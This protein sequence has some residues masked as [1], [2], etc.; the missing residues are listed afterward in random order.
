MK[1]IIWS[2]VIAFLLSLIFTTT[3]FVL[4]GYDTFKSLAENISAIGAKPAFWIG[5]A[6]WTGFYLLFF[7]F[8]V[9]F[10]K[11]NFGNN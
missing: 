7:T 10:I 8:P 4:F 2:I 1:R 3:W 9:A 6:A 5:V 11:N